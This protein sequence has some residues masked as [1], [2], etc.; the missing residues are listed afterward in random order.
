MDKC[1]HIGSGTL[2]SGRSLFC[3]DCGEL[4]ETLSDTDTC[5]HE[6]FD[7]TCFGDRMRQLIC[8]H[9]GERFYEEFDD[10]R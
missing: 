8:W 7:A 4:V 5:S 1:D 10:E 6:L 9:C 3:A 2:Q